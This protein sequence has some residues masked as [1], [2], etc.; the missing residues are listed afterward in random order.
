MKKWNLPVIAAAAVLAL[1]LTGC[2][3][4][5]SGAADSVY[6]IVP[7]ALYNRESG[8]TTFTRLPV[9]N[10][11]SIRQPE[12]PSFIRTYSRKSSP[13]AAELLDKLA[14]ALVPSDPAASPEPRACSPAIE[15][16]PEFTVTVVGHGESLEP[17][18]QFAECGKPDGLAAAVDGILALD[19]F[20][21]VILN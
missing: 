15:A 13:A 3:T 6:E 10:T 20:S 19:E 21:Q 18:Y 11:V 14:G 5:R 1:A 9:I 8:K 7:G 17:D 4:V 2:S 12:D 16:V